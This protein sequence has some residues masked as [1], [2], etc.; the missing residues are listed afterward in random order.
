MPL[1][2]WAIKG[3]WERDVQI[4]LA[5]LTYILSNGVEW[6]HELTI[7]TWWKEASLPG[8]NRELTWR[9][10]G[11]LAE[12]SDKISCLPALAY[13]EQSITFLF[14]Y[15]TLAPQPCLASN[16]IKYFLGCSRQEHLGTWVSRSERERSQWDPCS[17]LNLGVYSHASSSVRLFL[18]TMVLWG[19]ICHVH[20]LVCV[21]LLT[22]ST[23]HKVKGG[24]SEFCRYS[25][26]KQ[27]F[28]YLNVHMRML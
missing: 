23:K 14:C 8:P 18:V 1:L 25:V 28:V 19:C 7:T 5:I 4:P 2:L 20:V 3:K 15:T 26:K 12:W 13:T 27:E 22:I 21:L 9:A 6:L 24:G 16:H 10:D 11:G 17:G